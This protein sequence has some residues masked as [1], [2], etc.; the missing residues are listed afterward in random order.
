[1]KQHFKK[2]TLILP[3]IFIFLNNSIA[4]GYWQQKVDYKIAID[5][6]VKK[7]QY[8]GSERLVYTNNSPDTLYSVY[9][10]M[11]F[12]AF[13]P[14]SMM[15]VRSRT[16]DDPDKRVGDR[17]A[18]LKEDEI[19]YLRA[20][21]LLQ[22][23]KPLN[24][25]LSE[26][27]LEVQLATPILPG[28]SATL[29]MEF[30]GQ[31]PLQIRRSGRHNLGGVDYSMAQWFPK[32]AEYDEMGWHTPPYV[33]REFYAPWGNFDVSITIDKDWVLAG[34]GILQNAN[35][36][37]YGYE[38][39]GTKVKRKGKT[40]TWNFVANNVHDFVWAADPDYKQ[41]TAQVPDGPLLRFFYIPGPETNDTWEQL[42]AYTVKAFE[43][44]EANY[45]KYGW[46]EYA[47]I[48]GGDGGME[49][50]MATLI[51][52]KKLSGVRSLKS[53]VG[54]TIHEALHSW[55]QGMLATN[56]SY[57]PWMD[58]GFTSFAS[59][60]TEDHVWKKKQ[61]LPTSSMYKSYKSWAKTGLEEPLST[62][63]DHF[64][65]NK[66]YSIG[67]YTKGA[68]SLE[69]LAHIIGVENRDKGLRA[70][71]NQW[72]FKHP[73]LNDFIRV[74]EKQSGLELDWYYEYWVNTTATI[75][76]GI[77]DVVKNGS[78]TLVSLERIGQ[79]PMP[80]DVVIEKKD[81]SKVTYHIPLTI[82]RGEKPANQTNWIT[83]NDW[84]WTHPEY[85]LEVEIP[86]S[87]I[88]KITLNPEGRI[89]DINQDNDTYTTSG[90][91]N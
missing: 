47:V 11:Y 19:G 43:F 65:L 46:K 48:Q 69:Q 16:I 24:Y 72:K 38:D 64:T 61:D 33:G 74:M 52:N 82:M 37:G 55:Y 56:E 45:G 26:T 31:V 71:Y 60:Y 78:K 68:I 40:L 76:Y 23:G 14:N 54:V 50:P 7:H 73:D 4:Q 87:E 17:I 88:S 3:F 62:H 13:Q 91:E 1:M 32:M 75:D 8:T 81:G 34:T 29:A 63:A 85:Q 21:S 86:L 27:V 25:E 5:F 79:M 18:A 35:E 44:I 51:A 39:E 90:S 41:L 84:P 28:E 20:T 67:S 10:H 2:I 57:F 59:A 12:N 6:D 70:Y 42:P 77:T 89:A 49:Y 83:A 36:I 15:D 30:E 22:D 66:A 9:Y 58:E 53:L 80:Q